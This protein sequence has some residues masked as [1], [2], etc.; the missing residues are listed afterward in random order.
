MLVKTRGGEEARR[1]IDRRR[2]GV[3]LDVAPLWANGMKL[4]KGKDYVYRKPLDFPVMCLRTMVAQP[5]LH[6][7]PD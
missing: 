2:C 3:C 5:I 4:D 6:L 7:R 1:H